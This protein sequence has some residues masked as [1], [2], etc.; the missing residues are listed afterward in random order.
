MPQVM[1]ASLVRSGS[2]GTCWL[3]GELMTECYGLQIVVNKTKEQVPR[4]GAFMAGNKLMSANITGTVRLYNATSRLIERQAENLKAGRDSRFVIVSKLADPDNP[5]I[6]RVQVTGVSFD[7]L[8]LAD[9]Q[10]AQIGT[11]EAPFT[12]D[13]YTVLES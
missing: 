9:W 3:D 11:I 12:A 13:D 5:N 7:N 10:A 4:C 1:D 8:T 6:Q 2:H